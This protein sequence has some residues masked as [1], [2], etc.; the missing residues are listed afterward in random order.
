MLHIV[1]S[2][3]SQKKK[4]KNVFFYKTLLDTATEAFFLHNKEGRFIDVNKLACSSLGY[5]REELLEMSVKDVEVGPDPD[6]LKQLWEQ[7]NKGDNVL[8]EGKH[9]RKDGTIFPVE[10]SLGLIHIDGEL[11]FSVLARD[12]TNRKYKEEVINISEQKMALH[13][14]GTPMGV[15]EWDKNFCVS[16]WNPT[17]ETIFGYSRCEAIGLML[18][19]YLFQKMPSNMLI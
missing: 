7:L 6:G 15:I 17:A 10:V 9:R 13:I 2:V 12:I 3:R 19:N 1:N 14:Q 18:K 5:T 4:E 16:E 11:L 8:I